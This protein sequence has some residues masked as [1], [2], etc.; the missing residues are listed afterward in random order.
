M[1][2]ILAMKT[3][4]IETKVLLPMWE[5]AIETAFFPQKLM[6]VL[7]PEKQLSAW[8]DE[9]PV[10]RDLLRYQ[11]DAFVDGL[12]DYDKPEELWQTLRETD[13]RIVALYY[14]RL[15]A[16]TFAMR[17]AL[18]G[19]EAVEIPVSWPTFVAQMLYQRLPL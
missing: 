12:F 8:G 11:V 1:S 7:A 13:P 17:I 14:D 19:R 3:R 18:R 16:A 2:Y 6:A 10:M 4:F 5:A 15:N 9:L